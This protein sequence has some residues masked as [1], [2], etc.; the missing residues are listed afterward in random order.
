MSRN[1]LSRNAVST[2]EVP[3]KMAKLARKAARK[4]DRR[5]LRTRDALGD[6]LVRL[7]HEKP[8]EEITVQHILDGAGVSRS[9]FYTHFS[10][11]NDLFLS[12]AEEFFEM[13]ASALSEHRDKS[14]RLAPVREMFE[15]A[16]EWR[17]FLVAMTEAG[18]IQDVMEIGRESFARGIARRLAEMDGKE[19]AAA[20]G[21]RVKVRVSGAGP[22]DR[23]GPRAVATP[24]SQMLAGS[25]MGLM[26]W[27]LHTGQGLTAAEMDER[28]HELAWSGIR[29][30]GE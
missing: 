16:A 4:P 17:P 29:R 2:N 3:T 14:R 1:A 18:K 15:H 6:A 24:V 22:R 27:W 12:D 5:V 11:K 9:T 25:L 7:M 8:F 30:A 20:A 23:E 19:P 21:R 10:D 13:M 26:S 28:F